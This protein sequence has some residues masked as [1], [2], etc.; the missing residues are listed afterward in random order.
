MPFNKYQQAAIDAKLGKN[1]LISAGAGSGKTKTLSYKVYKLVKEDGIDPASLLVL[2]FTNKA[3]F[4]MKDRIIKQ[5]K[6]DKNDP[7]KY[8]DRIVSAHIQTFDSFS[9][10][11]AKKY[12]SRLGLPDNITVMDE[13]ILEAKRKEY[14][15]EVLNEMYKEDLDRMAASFRKFNVRKDDNSKG[16]IISIDDELNKMLDSDKQKFINDYENNYLSHD[17]FVKECNIFFSRL[18][19]EMRETMR[20]YYF[21]YITH[22]ISPK[23]WTGYLSQALSW[24]FDV[25]VP[26]KYENNGKFYDLL[27][28]LY[29]SDSKDI[30]AKALAY[31]NDEEYKLITSKDKNRATKIKNERETAMFANMV[32]VLDIPARVAEKYG[33]DLDSQYQVLLSFKDDV[34]LMFEIIRRMNEKLTRY[35][36]TVN[37]Y[38]FA[39]IGNKALSL[40]VDS[41]Y[42]DIAEEIKNRFKYILVDEYQD[43]ND[44]QET[45]L[46]SISEKATLF[47]VGDAKQS[48]YA[49]RNSNVQLFLDRREQYKK[50]PTKGEVINMNW[51]YRSDIQ[52][53]LDINSIFVHY[54]TPSHGNISFRE[55][56]EQLEVDPNFHR[57]RSEN[58]EYGIHWI[59]FYSREHKNDKEWEAKAILSDIETKVQSHYQVLREN[60]QNGEPLTRDCKYSDFAIL[61]RTKRQF[62]DYEELFRKVGIPF[63]DKVEEHLNQVNAIMALQSLIRLIADDIRKLKHPEDKTD[64]E[65]RLHLYLSLA[66]SYLYGNHNGYTDDKIYAS[67]KQPGGFEQDPIMKQVYEFSK[68]HKDS[69]LSVLFVDLL[70]EFNVIKELPHVGEVDSNLSKIE[71]FHQLVLSQ[72]SQGQNI[73]DFVNVIQ[74]LSRY[75]IELNASTVSERENAVK[76]MTI[77]S[78]KGLE[79]P[80]IYLP[81][82]DNR[83]SNG[84]NRSKPLSVFSRDYGILLPNY[85]LDE[86]INTLFLETYHVGEGSSQNEIDEYVRINYVAL[87][88]AKETIYLVG[89]AKQKYKESD[90]NESIYTMM[91]SSPCYPIIN[92]GIIDFYVKGKG[93]AKDQYDQYL[94]YEEAYNGF[95]NAEI[96]DDLAE[97]EKLKLTTLIKKTQKKLS[98]KMKENVDGILTE[99]VNQFTPRIQNASVD[100]LA[101]FYGMLNYKIAFHTV[102][103][104][105]SYYNEL[106]ER[107]M[108]EEMEAGEI[109]IFDFK[110]LSINDMIDLLEGF[111]NEQVSSKKGKKN[112]KT[113]TD[114]DRIAALIYAFDDVFVLFVTDIFNSNR[115]IKERIFNMDE[116]GKTFENKKT[117]N[118]VML[119]K[120]NIDKNGNSM[121]EKEIDFVVKAKKRRASMESKINEDEDLEMLRNAEYGTY[122]HRLLELVDFNSKDTSFIME[123]KERNIIDKVLAL[124]IFDNLCDAKVY[125]EYSYFDDEFLSEGIIDCVIIRK[126]R[127]DIIDYKTSDIDKP[128]YIDQLAAYS[129][130][131]RRLFPGK[132][133][134]CYLLSLLHQDVR[135]VLKE[136]L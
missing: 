72:E 40:L 68:R 78:S 121:E 35:K 19:N 27:V 53:L 101:T 24:D 31:K 55:K 92:P 130:N 120:V 104:L 59:K 28:D 36:E 71:S 115:N 98:G 70:S 79:F 103:E 117:V 95:V 112:D 87:T 105:L 66:R 57:P 86:K 84:D 1:V 81:F 48:I 134:H 119:P 107:E 108:K 65:N 22:D 69:P 33:T 14:L 97:E 6:E 45:F 16:M 30:L 20:F 132:E 102:T 29:H 114:E 52:V 74:N 11:L 4:E 10:Y 99:L 5:F 135:E 51:N 9:L 113:F 44:V 50:D 106:R 100:Q 75:S 116:F 125:H 85:K 41:Q 17:A 131:V 54:M 90:G 111:R 89:N 47:C 128:E 37:A 32:N 62:Q 38:T 73:F 64:K 109:P 43:T 34:Q 18:K 12:S 110:P 58:G 93:I 42:S 63:N 61:I 136:T 60:P 25:K 129:R 82:T 94:L 88:R 80:I 123:E 67:I 83:L 91:M 127:I 126:D 8:A 21:D 15:D 118:I 56:S 23:Y 124:P 2:T 26:F 7:E 13:S 3:A 76:L 39:E 96:P 49:F 133:T 77:H 46:N 122:L